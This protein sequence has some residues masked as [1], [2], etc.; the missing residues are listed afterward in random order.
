[1]TAA[2]RSIHLS[3]PALS[4]SIRAL[5]QALGTMHHS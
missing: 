5:E 4:G 2:A 1:M 3:Q